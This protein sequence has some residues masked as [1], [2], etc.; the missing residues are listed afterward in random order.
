VYT[1]KTSAVLFPVYTENISLFFVYKRKISVVLIG[2]YTE[3]ISRFDWCIHGKY[4]PF[5]S[6][7]TR[8]IS[9]N[10]LVYTRKISAVL[11]GVYTEN[12]SLFF[13]YTR[14]I[15]AV[16]FSCIHGKYQPFFS[17]IHGKYQPFCF[18]YTRKISAVLIGVYTENISSFLV[19]ISTFATGR[20]GCYR[21]PIE[22]QLHWFVAGRTVFYMGH[23]MACYIVHVMK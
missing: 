9:D 10:W 12:I 15:S 5:W 17:C 7:Y 11:I 1:W 20:A 3:N 16:F 22:I 19:K 21:I 13:V 14:K 23:V 18:V 8:K 2:V 6:V 4:Q